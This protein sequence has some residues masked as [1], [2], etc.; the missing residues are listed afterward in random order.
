MEN[1]DHQSSVPEP[2]PHIVSTL[3]EDPS[4]EEVLD[5]VEEFDERIHGPVGRFQA[6]PM[7]MSENATE[8][9]TLPLC[10]EKKLTISPSDLVYA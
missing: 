1:T 3:R 4:Q 2:S 9:G 7:E 5:I 10:Q 8:L 6:L